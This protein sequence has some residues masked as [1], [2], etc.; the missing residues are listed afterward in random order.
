MS[1]A[2]ASHTNEPNSRV[3]NRADMNDRAESLTDLIDGLQRQSFTRRFELQKAEVRVIE[4]DLPASP[5]IHTPS[6]GGPSG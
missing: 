5:E 2:N 1:E 3:S 4:R 6:R